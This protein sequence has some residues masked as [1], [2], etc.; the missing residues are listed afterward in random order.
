MKK[1]IERYIGKLAIGVTI[2][3]IEGLCAAILFGIGFCV[4]GAATIKCVE[5]IEKKP[6]QMDF[7]K[8]TFKSME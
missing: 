7:D 8:N 5:N 6:G 1:A 3:V 2:G 4:G